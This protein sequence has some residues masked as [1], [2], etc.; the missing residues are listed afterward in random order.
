ME[1]SIRVVDADGRPVSGAKVFMS[2]PFTW[3]EELTDDDGW[4]SFERDQT[5]HNGIRTDVS[6]D[7][8]T[9][10]EGEWFE[11]GDTRSFTV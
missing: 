10:A 1:I 7:G 11:D 8:E 9:V 6:I 4:A 5:I 2:Y 3:Q